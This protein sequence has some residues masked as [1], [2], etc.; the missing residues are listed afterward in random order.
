MRVWEEEWG[1]YG[2]KDLKT[3]HK[4]TGEVAL[5]RQR[6]GDALRD[7][8]WEVGVGCPDV[9]AVGVGGPSSQE[10]IRPKEGSGFLFKLR[11]AD[12]CDLISNKRRTAWGGGKR[13]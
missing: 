12:C 1:A 2:Q 10:R 7:W 4:T 9:R 8:G 11:E 13:G 3:G 6:S 5:R